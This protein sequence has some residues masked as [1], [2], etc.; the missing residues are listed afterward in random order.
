MDQVPTW[1]MSQ[2]VGTGYLPVATDD[3]NFHLG[4]YYFV[5]VEQIGDQSVSGTVALSQLLNVQVMANT[6]SKKLQ[7]Y[8]DRE[9]V[10]YVVF[11]LPTTWSIYSET[12]IE[13]EKLCSDLYP[14]IYLKKIERDTLPDSFESLEY[15]S[16]ADHDLVF[17]DNF[18]TMLN[19]DLV[20]NLNRLIIFIIFVFC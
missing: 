16:I 10:K 17:G 7:F 13:I 8:Y 5:S 20:S 14:T 19:E 6:V 2:Q 12:T 1:T 18:S 3:P 11:K 4:T 15:P 9:L